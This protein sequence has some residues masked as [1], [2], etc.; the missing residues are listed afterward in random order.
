MIKSRFNG[1]P[2]GIGTYF[3]TINQISV[4]FSMVFENTIG[5]FNDKIVFQWFSQWYLNILFNN[6][7]DFSGILNGI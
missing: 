1:T 3:S 7:S 2:N 6:K 4:V 5:P